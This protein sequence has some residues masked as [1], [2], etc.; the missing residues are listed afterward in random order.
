MENSGKLVNL[1]LL[2]LNITKHNLDSAFYLFSLKTRVN[3]RKLEKLVKVQ[4][5]SFLS[6]SEFFNVKSDLAWVG[7]HLI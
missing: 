2:G 3:I 7:S 1:T 6:F 5:S 4:N